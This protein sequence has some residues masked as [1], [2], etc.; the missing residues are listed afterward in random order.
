MNRDQL[1]C[2][3]RAAVSSPDPAAFALIAKSAHPADVA[4]ALSDVGSADVRKLLATLPLPARAGLFGYL[5]LETEVAVAAQLD[6]TELGE[7]FAHMSPDE[8]ADLF[9]RLPETQRESF[10]P[11]LAQVEREDI[12]KLALFPEGTA[13]A[14]MTSDYATLTPELDP[15]QA[16]DHLRKVA[17]DS[18]T[19]Y[20]AY[21][22]DADRKLIGAVS[23]K[24]LILA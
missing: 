24:D 10:L 6:R 16:I 2:S 4:A 11:A 9:N 23:L 14:V 21:V 19:I 13:G 12:R 17:P 15:S 1:F 20:Q 3:L 8:R 18:E 22:V 7:L 5:D